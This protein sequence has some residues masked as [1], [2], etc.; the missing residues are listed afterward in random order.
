ML[1]GNADRSG[2]AS[3][4]GAPQ[5]RKVTSGI[6]LA[7]SVTRSKR[8]CRSNRPAQRTTGF[9]PDVTEKAEL[10]ECAV[11]LSPLSL[12]LIAGVYRTFTRS[13]TDFAKRKRAPSSVA[14]EFVSTIAAER[15][16]AIGANCDTGYPTQCPSFVCSAQK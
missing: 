10:T 6:L 9:F 2:G 7:I 1:G 16:S 11:R 8:F 12:P 13:A 5:Q 14:N 15:N 4:T 3:S